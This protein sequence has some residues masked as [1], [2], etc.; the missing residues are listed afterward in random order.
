MA[1][2]P[3]TRWRRPASSTVSRTVWPPRRPPPCCV[4]ASSAT[5]ACGWSV[6]WAKGR[7]FWPADAAHEATAGNAPVKEPHRW[8]NWPPPATRPERLVRRLAIYGLRLGRLALHAGRDLARLGRLRVRSGRGAPQPCA[9]AWRG[10]GGPV[11]RGPRRRLTPPSSSAPP[12]S[13]PW[14]RCAAS[15]RA[16]LALGGIYSRPSRPSSTRGS[17]ASACRSVAN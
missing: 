13:W 9:R 4:P 15:T 17:T 8:P 10:L 11:R 5:A 2:L 16:A 7:G 12:A 1:V 14:M 6:S 3:S